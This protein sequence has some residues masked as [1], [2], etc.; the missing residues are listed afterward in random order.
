MKDDLLVGVFGLAAVMK[1]PIVLIRSAFSSSSSSQD[2][3]KTVDYA[4]KACAKDISCFVAEKLEKLHHWGVCRID[5]HRRR[6]KTFLPLDGYLTF[7]L[8]CGFNSTCIL[9]NFQYFK[10]LTRSLNVS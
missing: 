6:R 2:F 1:P 5:K 4:S 3:K 10:D 9:L 7:K 8:L